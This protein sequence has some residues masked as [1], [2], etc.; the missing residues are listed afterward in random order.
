MKKCF[1]ILCVFLASLIALSSCTEEKPENLIDEETYILLLIEVELLYAYHLEHRNSELTR[2]LIDDIMDNYGTTWEIFEQSHLYY[3]ED[4]QGQL[5]RYRKALDIL[6]A[7]PR[8][9]E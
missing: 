6:N 2:E 7:E 3:E 5:T 1:L 4:V 8:V 9:E